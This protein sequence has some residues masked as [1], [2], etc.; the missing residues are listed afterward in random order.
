MKKA[1][2]I[3][4]ID[5]VGKE[6][7]TPEIK[8][9]IRE[10]KA[11]GSDVDMVCLERGPGN[12]EYMY[13]E[14]LVMLDIIHLVKKAEKEGYDGAVIGCFYDPGLFQAREITNIVVTGPGEASMSLASTLGY[15]FSILAGRQ[16]WVPIIM[17]NVQKYGYKDKV[18]SVKTLELG[19][20]D[21]YK[22]LSHTKDMIKQMGKEAIDNDGAEVVILGCTMQ[23]GLYRE[24]QEYLDV[25]V[26][27]PIAAAL[28][29][30]E[31]LID[32]K[33][34]FGWGHSKKCLYQSP[35]ICQIKK[36]DIQ[37]QYN[38]DNLW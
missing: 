18:A 1:S 5:P 8:D 37:E 32:M 6:Y 11:D 34:S 23:F 10:I 22:D 4:Y 2:R 14:T 21:F 29:Q 16:K 35:P 28:K 9:F 15:K 19:V 31:F 26:I 27:D 3:L 13:Y 30:C 7:Y 36:Y 24:L 12:L 17:E 38:T 20:E 33:N 25:P